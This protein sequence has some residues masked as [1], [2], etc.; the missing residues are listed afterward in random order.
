VTPLFGRVAVLGLGLL[1]GSVAF[2]ARNRGVAEVV[3]GAARR[4]EVLEEAA[5]R[6]VVDEG[7]DFESVV[8]GAELVVLATPIAAMPE[9]VQRIA[10]C[11][12]KGTLVTDVGSVKAVLAE[13]LPGLL[14]RGVTYVGAHPMAGSHRNGLENARA[15]LFEGAPCVVMQT[16]SLAARDRVCS[17]WS[18][19]GARVVLRD[20]AQHDA[21]VAWM[22]HVPHVLAFAFGGAL[23]AAPDGAFDVQGSGFRDFTR[24]AQSDPELWSEIL[25]GNRKAVAA[26]LHAMQ[27]ALGELARAIE[28]NDV[29]AVERWLVA[30]RA[31]LSRGGVRGTQ[32]AANPTK[33][34]AV[35]SGAERARRSNENP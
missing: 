2:A 10:P 35:P 33:T 7:G 14:P 28:S 24:I 23:R 15:D 12:A 6:G 21:E 26:P 9:L 29:D 11:L 22:S 18:A 30:A 19:L 4:A 31:A 20:P 25:T 3:A 16:G 32:P 5:R 34:P 8:R 27:E 13:T 17:F 1:G